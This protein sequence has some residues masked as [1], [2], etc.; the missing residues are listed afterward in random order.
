[1][2]KK[3][4]KLIVKCLNDAQAECSCGHWRFQ[5]TGKRSIIEIIEEWGKHLNYWEVN[6]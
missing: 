2:T 4:C 6:K 1:M 5:G 3:K